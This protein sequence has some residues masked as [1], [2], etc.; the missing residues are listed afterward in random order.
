MGSH[1]STS[2]R[3]RSIFRSRSYQLTPEHRRWM[4]WTMIECLRKLPTFGSQELG[5]TVWA[6]TR[7]GPPSCPFGCFSLS[8]RSEQI[9]RHVVKSSSGNLPT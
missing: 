9:Y 1:T 4:D 7:C 8:L 2:P 3:S 6:L 5:T